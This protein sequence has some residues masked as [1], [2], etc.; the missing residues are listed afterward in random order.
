[1]LYKVDIKYLYSNCFYFSVLN[2]GIYCD[3]RAMCF[4]IILIN[5][6]S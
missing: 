6:K 4:F 3:I 5:W 2:E 1:M